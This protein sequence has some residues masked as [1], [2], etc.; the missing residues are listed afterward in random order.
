MIHFFGYELFFARW[1]I[2]AHSP[3]KQH[4]GLLKESGAHLLTAVLFVQADTIQNG[5]DHCAALLKNILQKEATGC[6]Y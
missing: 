5:L 4:L 1:Q 6:T 3:L 2:G